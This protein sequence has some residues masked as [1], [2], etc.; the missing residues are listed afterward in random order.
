MSVSPFAP[1]PFTVPIVSP[2]ATT[3]SR[4][5][6]YISPSELKAAPTALAL[7]NLVPGGSA[8]QQ[9]SE[10]YNVLLRASD[11]VDLICFHGPDGTLAASPTVQAGWVAPKQGRLAL[12]CNF[13]PILAVTGVALGAGPQ[14]LSDIGDSAAQG[15]SIDS[16]SIIALNNPA[17]ALSGISVASAWPGARRWRTYAVWSYIAGYP[18]MVLAAPSAAG[19]ATLTV[20]SSVPGQSEPYGVYPGTQ[21]TVR[22]PAQNSGVEVCVVSSVAGEVLTLASPLRYKHVV[23][24]VPDFVY[25][26]ALPHAVEQACISLASCLIKQRGTRAAQMASQPG[27]A[28]SKGALAQAGALEDYELAIDNL[29]PFISVYR[30]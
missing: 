25:V 27:G 14:S 2:S 8:A 17:P 4:R 20:A 10:L 30:A 15:V 3:L 19:D 26:T 9:A 28:T 7:S 23:P 29:H 21:L 16:P 6:P 24:A 13:R 1:A 11:W 22:D 5:E 18:H 12:V